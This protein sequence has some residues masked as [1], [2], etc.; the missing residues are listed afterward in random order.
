MTFAKMLIINK[1]SIMAQKRFNINRS[2]R[3]EEVKR[4]KINQEEENNT[5]L[6]V[7]STIEIIP[8]LPTPLIENSNDDMILGIGL[9]PIFEFQEIWSL[10]QQLKSNNEICKRAIF[11]IEN[12]R[13]KKPYL[14]FN[15]KNYENIRNQYYHVQ[16]SGIALMTNSLGDLE[17][18]DDLRRFLKSSSITQ[19][20]ANLTLHK[21]KTTKEDRLN[22]FKKNHKTHREAT[23][24]YLKEYQIS[25]MKLRNLHAR[26]SKKLFI[27]YFLKKQNL[28][29]DL[30]F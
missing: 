30:E 27:G 9:N 3:E 7:S 28:P 26:L 23:N 11:E 29:L 4:F 10:T 1:K 13:L 8:D 22:T 15:K 5:S 14:L 2:E 25:I 24:V 19:R 20:E 6:E 21:D 18:I 12:R 17:F 16:N